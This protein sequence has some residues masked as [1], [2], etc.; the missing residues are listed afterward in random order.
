MFAEVAAMFQQRLLQLTGYTKQGR[1][2]RRE[3]RSHGCWVQ[4]MQLTARS[5]WYCVCSGTLAGIS[6]VL[7][8]RHLTRHRAYLARD[9]NH[10]LRRV[11]V[12]CWTR[13]HS[14]IRRQFH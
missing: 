1:L 6:F 12:N 10:R 13:R 2:V 11:S 3:G 8:W 4:Q 14:G 9:N 5:V 7:P